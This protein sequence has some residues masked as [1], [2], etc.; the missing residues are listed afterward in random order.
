MNLKHSVSIQACGNKECPR[1]I[2]S[3]EQE[4]HA[5][6]DGGGRMEKDSR[7]IQ[8]RRILHHQIGKSYLRVE[9]RLCRQ[10]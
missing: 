9:T 2:T 1:D 5:W 6:A 3:W 10:I 4:L 7:K 8:Q